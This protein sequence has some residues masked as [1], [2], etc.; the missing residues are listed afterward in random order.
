M[1]TLREALWEGRLNTA[2]FYKLANEAEKKEDYRALWENEIEKD[3][4]RENTET[5]Q[6]KA[7]SDWYA[8]GAKY[9]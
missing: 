4:L 1:S 6:D 9:V 8:E 5:S 2:E 3:L 7:W